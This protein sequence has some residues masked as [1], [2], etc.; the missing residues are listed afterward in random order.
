[1]D[2]TEAKLIPD[3][4]CDGI[5]IS[6]SP[7][8]M[9]M[10]LTRRSPAAGTTE[11]PLTVGYVRMS[12]EHAKVFAIMLRNAVKQNEDQLGKPIP[13]HPSLRAQLGISPGEDW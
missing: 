4:Y 3:L 5:A 7:F 8:D 2:Q 6:G 9:V 1:M 13:I 12:W 11:T 10:Q